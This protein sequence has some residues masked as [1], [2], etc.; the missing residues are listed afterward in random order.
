[1]TK[2]P[3]ICNLNSDCITHLPIQQLA[4]VVPS[5]NQGRRLLSLPASTRYY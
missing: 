3:F 2:Q 1:M 5:P 4:A